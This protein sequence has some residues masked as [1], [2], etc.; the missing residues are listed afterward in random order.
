MHMIRDNYKN[1]IAYV[2]IDIYMYVAFLGMLK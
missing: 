1:I 2:V